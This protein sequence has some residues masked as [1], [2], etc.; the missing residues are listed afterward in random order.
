MRNQQDYLGRMASGCSGGDALDQWKTNKRLD[1]LEKRM[2]TLEQMFKTHAA[3]STV[4]GDCEIS[5]KTMVGPE[6][7]LHLYSNAAPPMKQGVEE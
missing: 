1:A 7:H 6:E 3:I 2:D 4:A 5:A